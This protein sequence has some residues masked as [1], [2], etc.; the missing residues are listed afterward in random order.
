[1]HDVTVVWE[2]PTYQIHYFIMACIFC[3]M[4]CMLYCYKCKNKI[5][6]DVGMAVPKTRESRGGGGYICHKAKDYGIQQ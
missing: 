5:L 6:K 1:M 4:A 3:Y 2:T